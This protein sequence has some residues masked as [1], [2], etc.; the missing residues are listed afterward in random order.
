M[1][2]WMV[3]TIF[4]STIFDQH[5]HSNLTPTQQ[6]C[7][8]PKTLMDELKQSQCQNLPEKTDQDLN[9]EEFLERAK[10]FI[11]LP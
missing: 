2:I 8:A 3:E 4:S 1:V 5:E 11:H 10:C 7:A 9:C 6:H